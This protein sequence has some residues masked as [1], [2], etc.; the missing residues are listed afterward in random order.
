MLMFSG[1]AT[2][3]YFIFYVLTR[4]GLE[5]TIYPTRGEHANQYA[6]DAAKLSFDHADYPATLILISLR[7]KRAPVQH[8]YM[9]KTPKEQ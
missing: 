6:T 7:N 2:N 5:P 9:T 1:D 3:T 8:I 4:S